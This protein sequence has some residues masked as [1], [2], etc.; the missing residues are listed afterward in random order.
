MVSLNKNNQTA[1][2]Y[3]TNFIDGQWLENNN[4]GFKYY[5]I[6]YN[7]IN[8]EEYKLPCL[9][10]QKNVC[11][12]CSR[13]IDNSPETELEHIIPRAVND[14][15]TLQQYFNYSLILSQSI[16]LQNSF[17]AATTQQATPPFPHHIAYQ[18][19][20]A[21]CNGKTINTSEDTTCCNRNRGNEF[22]PPFN[23]INNCIAYN[24][25]GSIYYVEDDIHNQYINHL[26][27]NK[28]LLKNIRRI[29]FL[30][31]NS[32]VTEDLLLQANTIEEFKEVFSI[33][34]DVN[35]LKHLQKVIPLIHLKQ[36]QI[37]IFY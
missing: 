17:S 5:N 27:L 18:N 10:E 22:I 33:Y 35:P 24:N 26:N 20:L 23:L 29:W 6:G 28:A 3:V 36:K 34:I 7:N 37:G 21:S 31:A 4:G 9:Q 15:V 19:I 8:V 12:Y 25:D 30:F 11:C 1:I 2:D 16:V 14:T 32:D 13:L